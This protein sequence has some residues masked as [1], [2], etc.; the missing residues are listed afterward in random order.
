MEGRIFNGGDG[1]KACNN[2]YECEY[3]ARF[4][5]DNDTECFGF[6]WY[7]NN[8]KLELRMCTSAEMEP[9]TDSTTVFVFLKSA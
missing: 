7:E 6:S 1:R 4:K 5:C 8:E 3:R 9:K 2:D